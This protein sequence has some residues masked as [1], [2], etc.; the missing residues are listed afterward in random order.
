MRCEVADLSLFVVVLVF[1]AA[2]LDAL[3]GKDA[4]H[5]GGVQLA[6]ARRVTCEE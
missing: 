4:E 2:E 6:C 1:D 3:A 5:L